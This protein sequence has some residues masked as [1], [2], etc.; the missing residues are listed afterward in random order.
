[1]SKKER[2]RRRKLAKVQERSDRRSAEFVMRR[3]EEIQTE[4]SD[5][6]PE[7]QVFEHWCE[8]AQISFML[9]LL[10]DIRKKYRKIADGHTWQD[11]E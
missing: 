6:I 3:I 7:L 4:M 2:K 10:K 11:D 5:L 1:M 8:I 9:R